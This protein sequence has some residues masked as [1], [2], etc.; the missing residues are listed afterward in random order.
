MFVY[1]YIYMYGEGCDV[2][3][4]QPTCNPDPNTT[5]MELLIMV[6]RDVQGYYSCPFFESD[7]LF[8]EGYF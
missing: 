3:V 1:I 8:L 2:Y 7:T 5:L 4:V 6:A